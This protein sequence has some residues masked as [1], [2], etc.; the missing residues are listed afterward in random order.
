MSAPAT[1]APVEPVKSRPVITCGECGAKLGTEVATDP[2]FAK[3]LFIAHR[4]LGQ[5]E[6][7][8]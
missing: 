1:A 8:R 7:L 6:A 5:C 3:R 2:S 4:S